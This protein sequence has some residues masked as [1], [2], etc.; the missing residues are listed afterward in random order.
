[1]AVFKLGF[2]Q[3][4]LLLFI[5]HETSA[6]YLI[7]DYYM[8]P[9]LG[10]AFGGACNKRVEDACLFISS[11]LDPFSTFDYKSNVECVMTMDAGKMAGA[12]FRIDWQFFN[13]EPGDCSKDYLEIY[14]C[15]LDE[16]NSTYLI[17]RFCG[18]DGVRLDGLNSRYI[19]LKFKTDGSTQ[20]SGFKLRATR[21]EPPPC[22]SDEFLCNATGN[23]ECIDDRL[24]CDGTQQCYDNSDE[25]ECSFID[26]LLGSFFALGIGGMAG[27]GVAF[28]AGCVG[29]WTLVGAFTCCK[30]CC[31]KCC[32]CW[33]CCKGKCGNKKVNPEDEDIYLDDEH[34]TKT[35]VEIEM[36]ET[37]IEDADE[38]DDDKMA[39]KSR[40]GDYN[41]KNKLADVE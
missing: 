8:D 9:G 37:E 18:K 7:A 6:F 35:E 19:T 41:E 22:Q 3:A 26:E 5:Y 11:H 23:A 24:V 32:C 15:D 16:I 29:L 4:L 13:L 28:I 34:P 38:F 39:R 14:N 40:M 30:K 25:S 20:M 2:F 21:Y 17:G 27:C 31:V 33:P 12:R 1:M 10:N 36:Q